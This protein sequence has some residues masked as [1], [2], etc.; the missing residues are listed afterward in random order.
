MKKI[1][2]NFEL[3]VDVSENGSQPVNNRGTNEVVV[4]EKSAVGSFV[5]DNKKEKSE[6]GGIGCGLLF[7]EDK[8]HAVVR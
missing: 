5:L 6:L 4:Q 8:D 2:D 7:Q 1:E 3:F